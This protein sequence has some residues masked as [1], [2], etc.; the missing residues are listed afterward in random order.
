MRRFAITALALAVVLP[1]TAPAQNHE[2]AAPATAGVPLFTNLGTLHHAIST[3][4]PRAQAYFDQGLRL[5][6]G[7]NHEEAVNSFREAARLDP[8]CAMCWWGAALALGPNINQ[9]MDSASEAAAYDAVREAV[10]RQAHATPAE[11]AYVRALALRY[12]RPAGAARGARDSAYAEAMRRV[13]AGHPADL[14]AATLFAESMLDLRPWDQ[15]TASGQAQPGTDEVVRT[16]EGVLSRQPRHPGACHYYIHT[17][18]GSRTADRALPCAERLPALMPGAGHLVHMPAHV[19][20]RLGMYDRASTANEHAAHTD[21]TY[22]EGRHPTGGYPFY[23]AHNLH[24]LWAASAAEGRGAAAL[25]AARGLAAKI[26]PQVARQSPS[27][28]F[29]VPTPLYA[30]VQFGRWNDVLREPAPDPALRYATAM[31]RHARGLAF[32]ATGRVDEAGAEADSVHAILLAT[33]GDLMVGMHPARSLLGIADGV[34]S[35]RV[36]AARGDTAGAE[37]LLR[38]AVELEDGL[39]YDEPPPWYSPVRL[40]LGSL[41]LHG[42]RPAE[43]EAVFRRD[44]EIHPRSAWSLYGLAQA[45]EAQGRDAAPTRARYRAA[46]ARADVPQP[47]LW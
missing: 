23:Y 30:L 21:E 19:Y 40:A 18:E 31:W 22:L 33:P 4:S 9:P 47:P 5:T 15:W 14:D 13:A 45:L 2:H 34:L 46:W 35:G 28:E 43:A 1:G 3:R 12:G 29:F 25:Q 16:L 44:L 11:R 37:A 38:R 27:A 6:Y 10:S 8:Q 20:M 17:V 7:F 36:Q 41:L 32:A 26:S 39:R 24:F 42:G